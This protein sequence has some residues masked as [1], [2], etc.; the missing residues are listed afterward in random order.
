MTPEGWGYYLPAYLLMALSWDESDIVGDAVVG[1]LTHPRAREAAFTQ[2]ALDL[3]LEPEAVLAAH[4]ER[5]EQR[6]SGLNA[7]EVDATRAVL[8]YLAERVDADNACFE[9]ALPNAPRQALESWGL[10]DAL[11]TWQRKR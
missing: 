11:T 3:G 7:A 2:V 1:A 9:I 10:C 4:S 6:L 5:F 8:A